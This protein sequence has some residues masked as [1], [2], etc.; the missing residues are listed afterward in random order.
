M[1]K[2]SFVEV[3]Q[4]KDELKRGGGMLITLQN[5]RGGAVSWQLC[6]MFFP[7]YFLLLKYSMSFMW[8]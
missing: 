7:Q 3:S 2:K 6:D 4:K 1:L 5:I 8:Y